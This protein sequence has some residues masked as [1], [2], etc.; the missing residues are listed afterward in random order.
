MYRPLS[1]L[2]F[3]PFFEGNAPFI[4]LDTA[5]PD[6][7]N[8]HSFIFMNPIEILSANTFCDVRLLLRKMDAYSRKFW[9]AGYLSYE[10]AYGLDDAFFSL[11]RRRQAEC[12]GWFG[13]FREPYIFDHST[14][15]WNRPFPAIRS[16]RTPE[17]IERAVATKTSMLISEA[18]YKRALH[19]VKRF[20]AKGHTYQI[21]FTYDVLVQTRRSAFDLYRSLRESQPA[22]FCAFLM[23][24]R[25]RVASFSPELFFRKNNS[26][27]S[28]APMKGT[29][30]RGRFW[31]EDRAL[32]EA[33]KHDAKNRSENVMIV[34]LMRNDLG[35]M[36]ATGSIAASR[37]YAIET[38]PTLHQMTTTVKGIVQPSTTYERIFNSLFPSGSVTG[39]PKIRS[40][41]I[42]RSLEKGFRGVYCG[43]IGYCSPRSNAVFSVPIRTLQSAPGKGQWKYRVGSGIVWDSNASEEW[44]ECAVKCAFLTNHTPDFELFESVLWDKRLVYK[45]DHLVRFKSSARYFRFPLDTGD[46][47]SLLVRIEKELA[48][49]PPRKVRIFLNKKGVLR[50]DCSA[51]GSTVAAEGAAVLFCTQPID[52]RDPF[53]FHKTTHRP[54]YRHDAELIGRGRCF[55]VIHANSKGQLTEGSRCNIFVRKGPLLYTPE[56][57]CGLLPG[58][59]RKNLLRREKCKEAIMTRSDL[60]NADAIYCG[61]SVRGLI[62]VNLMNHR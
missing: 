21:N 28:V 33:L 51:L 55:D 50:W 4:L 23:N 41:E 54:W 62:E 13:V 26:S 2:P 14:G 27:I 40:M 61:N 16:K 18:R 8:R 31:E 57:G 20:I 37:P 56:V 42:I 59:L 25:D 17:G 22:A 47:S 1:L 24:G 3:A 30:R 34:D 53:M 12:L 9:V 19:A 15:L 10:A 6:V 29:A 5:R 48:D 45:N 49:G 46:L 43:A 32:R 58:I 44:K 11:T 36:C 60:K 7:N 52:E 39:A 35:K 38:L